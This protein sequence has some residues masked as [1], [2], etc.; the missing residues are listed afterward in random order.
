VTAI[1]ATESVFFCPSRR[2][3]QQVTWRDAF[4]PPLTGGE[5]A[6][7]LCDYAASNHENTGVIQRYEPVRMRHVKDGS[8]ATFVLADKRLNRGRL[9]KPQ[10]D[11]N[12]GFSAGWNSDTIRRSDKRP[13]QDFSSN[14]DLNGDNLFGSSHPG[15]F[16]AV[17]LDGSVHVLTYDLDLDVFQSMGGI[18]DGNAKRPRD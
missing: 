1:A 3:P 8:S 16:Q 15:I 13:E 17:F 11:D 7:G 2:G 4:D 14:S 9:G 6:R 5:L 10:E 18:R 12:E